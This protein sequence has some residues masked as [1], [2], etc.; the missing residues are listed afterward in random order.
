MD[1]YDDL[2]PEH[3]LKPENFISDLQTLQKSR[4]S[5]KV[6]EYWQM[7][8]NEGS[9][10]NILQESLDVQKI[11]L[12]IYS[13]AS[14]MTKE[15]FAVFK[16]MLGIHGHILEFV[17]AILNKPKPNME[18]VEYFIMVVK[19]PRHYE[20][21][22]IKWFWENVY[23]VVQYDKILSEQFLEN[24]SNSIHRWIATQ[25]KNKKYIYENRGDLKFRRFEH[26]VIPQKLISFQLEITP[27]KKEKHISYKFTKNIGT[28]FNAWC[29]QRKKK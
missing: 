7:L 21:R 18:I 1:N 14:F 17:H 27:G 8:D 9:M 13:F 11:K 20:P 12:L 16:K 15:H 10:V 3:N 2:F 23:P 22:I 28:G 24:C 25:K 4:S 26:T 6:I 19:S 29:S 5:I